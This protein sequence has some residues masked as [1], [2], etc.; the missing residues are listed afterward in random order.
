M[1]FYYKDKQG[2]YHDFESIADAVEYGLC[3]GDRSDEIAR[4]VK[5]WLCSWDSDDLVDSIVREN[6]KGMT[7]QD[8]VEDCVRGEYESQD[9]CEGKIGPFGWFERE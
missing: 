6:F 8:M 7:Y 4:M 2:K 3:K 1:L 5:T 9:T